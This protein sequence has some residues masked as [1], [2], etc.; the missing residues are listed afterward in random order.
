ML[1]TQ[2][3]KRFFTLFIGF[4]TLPL[5]IPDEGR[6]LTEIFIFTLLCGALKGFMD[7][8][9]SEWAKIFKTKFPNICDNFLKFLK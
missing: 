5:L 7:T 8:F 4:L 2:H 9:F 3:F 6:K 1:G